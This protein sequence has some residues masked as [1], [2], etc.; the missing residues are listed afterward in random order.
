MDIP[1][2]LLADLVAASHALMIVF[3]FGVIAFTFK[4]GYRSKI[5][6]TWMIAWNTGVP[7]GATIF[8]TCPITKLEKYLRTLGEEEVYQGH[9]LEHYFH[10]S[11]DVVGYLSII[12]SILISVAILLAIRKNLKNHLQEA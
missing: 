3:T 9:F 5:V 6:I 12:M 8:G 7:L 1:Y 2:S 4:Y 11:G 10:L